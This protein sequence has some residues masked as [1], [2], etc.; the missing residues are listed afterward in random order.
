ML[1]GMSLVSCRNHEELNA[2]FSSDLENSNP[3]SLMK[4]TDSSTS[5]DSLSAVDDNPKDPHVI[6]TQ[7]KGK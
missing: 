6:R 3:R 5:K 1:A 7:W 4:K 2:E